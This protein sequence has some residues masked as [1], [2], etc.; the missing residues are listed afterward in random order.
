MY[1][2][3]RRPRPFRP[4]PRSVHVY[5]DCGWN[6]IQQPSR[7]HA[8]RPPCSC[9]PTDGHPDC[10][11][12]MELWARLQR[13]PVKSH[14]CIS[15]PACE[16]EDLICRF[17]KKFANH[18]VQRARLESACHSASQSCPWCLDGFGNQSGKS[19]RKEAIKRV[20]TGSH[21]RV[22]A[23]G[24]ARFTIQPRDWLRLPSQSKERGGGWK[25]FQLSG[26]VNWPL[27]TD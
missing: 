20:E 16:Y 25:V 5:L 6:K 23:D 8:A 12:T 4:F 27:L 2:V 22:R 7:T 10:V 17:C 19:H 13:R 15:H 3:A 1:V 26:V 9:S 24:I 18:P 21:L 11:M 14:I